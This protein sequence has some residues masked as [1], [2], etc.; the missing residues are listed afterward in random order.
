MTSLSYLRDCYSCNV[1]I[2]ENALVKKPTK[3]W[4]IEVTKHSGF[5]KLEFWFVKTRRTLGQRGHFELG[6]A[7]NHIR[8]K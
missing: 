6:S 3:E 1:A 4:K 8:C 7:L 5:M 2:F